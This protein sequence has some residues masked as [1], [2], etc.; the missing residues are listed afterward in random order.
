MVTKSSHFEFDWWVVQKRAVRIAVLAF[1]ICL[2]VSG[3]ALYVWKF[4]NP[5]E[6][7][8]LQLNM[9]AGA[10]SKVTCG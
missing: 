1:A 6:R 9:P 4:G 7:V 10:R 8:A 3:V 5:L 2:V